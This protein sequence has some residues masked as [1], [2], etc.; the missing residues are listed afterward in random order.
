M[1]THN[2]KYIFLMVILPTSSTAV[3]AQDSTGFRSLF[4]EGLTLRVG[5]GYIAVRD[6]F[7]SDEKF[8]SSIPF[9]G[10]TW[11]KYHET[12][13]FRL[14]LEYQHTSNLK[15]YN[16]SAEITQFRLV[17][18]YLYPISQGDILSRKGDIILGPTCELFEHYRRENIAGSENLQSGITLISGGLR[19]EAFW[20]L[21]TSLQLRAA[22]ELTLLSLSLRTVN[23]NTNNESP[24]KLLTLFTGIDADGEIG[25][26]CRITE[27]FYGSAG[28]RF[29]VTRVS[30]WDSFIAA[31][32]N[33]IV[34]LSYG[35]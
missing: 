21:T 13:D 24:A 14:H 29:V 7:I 11:S 9:F 27:S 6:E 16:V 23:S 35:F 34:S 3:L 20:P 31:S 12:Y 30:A 33:L 26:S 1:P 2:K 8:S 18:D 32:D 28:Y 17:L 19:S 4:G 25:I 15:N 5:I 10:V 22:A